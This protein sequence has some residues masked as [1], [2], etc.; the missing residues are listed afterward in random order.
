[1]PAQFDK[2]QMPGR[3]PGLAGE[4]E[5]AHAAALTP[6]AQMSA[7]GLALLGHAGI[8]KDRHTRLNYLE[9]NRPAARSAQNSPR[10]E[11]R[12]T[13]R[14][15]KQSG[16]NSSLKKPKF[17]ASWENTGKFIDSGFRCPNSSPKAQ[18]RSET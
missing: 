11:V 17:P 5:L 7:N 1:V 4:V 12:L 14:W 6:L 15:R 10:A 18:V 3:D 13:H 2:A 8:I 16:A 9:R